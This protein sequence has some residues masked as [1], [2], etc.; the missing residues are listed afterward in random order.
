MN[1][2]EYILSGIVESYV[3][4]LANE[5]ERTEF[6]SMCAVHPEVKSARDSFEILLEQRLLSN[7]IAPA[8]N[9]RSQVLETLEKQ[10]QD[11]SLRIEKGNVSNRNS[12]ENS[13][14]VTIGGW[15]KYAA[16]ASIILLIGSTALNFYFFNQYK[17]VSAKYDGLVKENMDFAKNDNIL[18]TSIG[19]YQSAI[20][21]LRNPSMAIIKMEGNAVPTSPDPSSMATVY[22][23]RLTK[24][25][26]LFVNNL[27]DPTANK[28][29]QLWAIVD[30]VPID[31][32]VFTIEKGVPV[33]SM[34]NIP[35]A[36]AFAITL[37]NKGG[38]PSPL[39]QMYVLGKV[40]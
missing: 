33:I 29:Y 32:G 16:V 7:A 10:N 17:S 28:Q 30:G 14:V 26:F 1:I 20:E 23:D 25:V 22:W 9:V 31:A 35:R 40:T 12:V 19:E 21:K 5:Q 27:P 13:P 3:L 36:Q 38:S 4:G 18:R 6:E 37:E 11:T 15:F 34:K 39:G 24:D 8:I 2:Q